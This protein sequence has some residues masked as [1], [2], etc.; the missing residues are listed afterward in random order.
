MSVPDRGTLEDLATRA[1]AIALRNF[2]R[3]TP[4]RKADR[5]LVTAADREVEAFLVEQL[6]ILWPEA[7]IVGE[8]GA[9]RAGSGPYR[10][11]IDPVDGTSAFVAGL[12]TWCVCLGVLRDGEPVAGVVHLPVSA[13]TY[14]A[15]DGRAWW[16]G[17]ALPRLG[18]EAGL[19]DP[20][21]LVDAKSHRRQA[22]RYEGKLRS[23]GSSAYHIALVARGA[24]EATLVGRAHVWDLAAPTAVLAAVGG[25][26][27]L[28]DGGAVDLGELVDGRRTRDYVV[29]AATDRFELLRFQLGGRA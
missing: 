24:A 25:R 17:S 18:S 10:V 5:T 21:V 6:D 16:N 11:A 15:T 19:G 22:I 3:A 2:R 4:E 9:A 14:S 28:L 29:A 12:P 26:L 13:E 8:E 1:G 20:F 27:G 23:L 7:G